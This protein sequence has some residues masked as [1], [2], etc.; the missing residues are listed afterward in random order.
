MAGLES[1]QGWCFPAFICLWQLAPI[2]HESQSHR[3]QRNTQQSILESKLL[4]SVV[5]ELW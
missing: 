4:D 3:E 2:Q 5:D 1:G